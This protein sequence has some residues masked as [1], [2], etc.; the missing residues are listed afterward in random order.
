MID[1]LNRRRMLALLGG[2]FIAPRFAGAETLAQ[3]DWQQVL[4]PRKSMSP[5]SRRRISQPFL[6]FPAGPTCSNR[7]ARFFFITSL[8]FQCPFRN[9][10]RGKDHYDDQY[11]RRDGEDGKF[12]KFGGY[13]RERPLAAG[14][15]SSPHWRQINFAIEI[16]R[17][18]SSGADEL[19]V[20]M[21]RLRNDPSW[22]QVNTLFDT[23]A[24][25]VPDFRLAPEPDAG[26]LKSITP[27][28]L[29]ESLLELAASPAAYRLN[30]GRFLVSAFAPENYPASFWRSV[31]KR[32]TTH[33]TPIAFLPVF[34]A[35]IRNAPAFAPFSYG[36][37]YWGAKD[38]ATVEN[39][40]DNSV[41]HQLAAY[42][43]V[44]MLPITPQDARPKVAAFSEAGNTQLFRD[45][46]RMEA[47]KN[48]VK[49]I[50][51][52]TW[53]DYS[54]STEVSPSSGT[55]F[56]FYDLA[57]YFITWFKMG[58]PPQITRDAM[59]YTHRRQLIMPGVS[60]HSGDT[61]M[62]LS[63]PTPV[64]K[65][66]RTYCTADTAGDH[67]NRSRREEI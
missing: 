34:L 11:L 49:F 64:H 52:I 18:R 65:T 2:A 66:D 42:S 24:A 12:A 37:S 5:T 28:A 7:A 20:D 15:W 45:L 67:P 62:R 50:Q 59:Y 38:I 9:L 4:T 56:V 22:A 48:N 10:P 58:R 30:D 60:H 32:M 46:S 26:A 39:G 54:E 17:A 21:L 53:N 29:V 14:P 63:G 6:S 25:I 47:I 8:R 16:L 33:K 55:Q 3:P 31:V 57:T 36:L 19:M 44:V 40:A 35:P 1:G 61:P 23:A 51:L 27:D 13:L 41:L 43:S